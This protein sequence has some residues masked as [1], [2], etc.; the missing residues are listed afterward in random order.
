M[1]SFIVRNAT[2]I[3]TGLD[4]KNARAAGPD[5]RVRDG[6]IEAL[7]RLA[8]EPSE[9]IYD[10][11]D[12]VIYPGWVNTHHHLFQSMLKGVP[13]GINLPLIQWLAAVPVP[14][15][16]FLDEKRLRLAATIGIAELLL[17]GC[18]TIADHHYGYWPGMPFD[19]GA[20]LFEVAERFGVRF[21]LLRGGATGVRDDTDRDAPPQARPET[22]DGF[23][24]DVER[25][26]KRFHQPAGDATRKVAM[27]P[28]SP[29]WSVRPEEL[30]EFIRAARRLGIRAHTHLSETV[31]YVRYCRDVHNTTPVEF[32][33]KHEWLGP[34]VW[35]AHLVHL[36]EPEI[37]LLGETNTG[38]AHCPQSN[39]RLGSG[40]APVPAL[41]R[42]GAQASIGVDGAAS[43]EAADMIMETH[44]S[45][46]VHRVRGGA[47]AVTIE[48]VVRWGTSGG[49]RVLGFDRVGVLA[50]GYC[51]D[52]VV[53]DL[54][55][56]RYAGLHDPA[57]G[58]VAAG[59]AAQVRYAFC[60]G[61]LVVEN[62]CVP[63]LDLAA[64][65]AQARQSVM[66]MVNQ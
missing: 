65:A 16:R 14:Y 47:D 11:S 64:L 48:D 1:T 27:A 58:P 8:P 35:F 21:A 45:W 9:T 5:I 6:V 38:I 32:V 10:A 28:T 19:A 34:D 24:A 31:D 51:A 4:G 44:T 46:F 59:G 63:G 62:G 49:A 39:C 2:A 18:T 37:K 57:I 22:L 17:S 20:L 7:G 12:C 15:R 56:P 54:T 41:E 42:A 25:L 26:V 13:A 43:N 29:T 52:F 60:H 40:I 33:A 50:P 55:A 66:E 23:I 36:S 3:L 61:R 30:R 53:Y